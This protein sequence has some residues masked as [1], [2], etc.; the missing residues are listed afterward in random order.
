MQSNRA[1][2]DL[3]QRHVPHGFPFE[4]FS[5]KVAGM[6]D[7]TLLKYIIFKLT[8]EGKGF[9]SN[10]SQ[11][12]MYLRNAEDDIQ[13]CFDFG[14][15][16]GQRSFLF[17]ELEEYLRDY[18]KAGVIAEKDGVLVIRPES[19]KEVSANYKNLE[20]GTKRAISRVYSTLESEVSAHE[21]PSGGLE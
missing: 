2:R 14:S 5:S 17:R 7:R 18:L 10:R 11:A 4:N 20:P 1:F 8:K 12:V 16:S 21:L 19:M 13:H 15:C 6:S 3:R 9:P